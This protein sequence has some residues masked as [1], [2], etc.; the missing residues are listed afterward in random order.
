VALVALSFGVAGCTAADGSDSKFNLLQDDVTPGAC[1]VL[2]FDEGGTI[3]A[4]EVVNEAYADIG[5]AISSNRAAVAF[6]SNN[7][8]GEDFDLA[9]DG[10][11]NLLIVQEDFSTAEVEAGLVSEP[12]DNGS[13]GRLDFDF[14]SEVCVNGLTVLDVDDDEDPVQVR[15]YGPDGTEIGS[16]GV[17]PTG[18]N[19]RQ[20]IVT[21]ICGVTRMEVE[22][23]SSGA[24]DNVEVCSS[25][26]NPP[27]GGGGGDDP[28]TPEGDP[29]D[30]GGDGD[31]PCFDIENVVCEDGGSEPGNEDDY[32]VQ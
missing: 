27:G 21:S 11:G 1:K 14:A 26:D 31:G 10:L 25:G 12:D 2:D 3:A 19:T 23:N 4:G 30:D 9:F 24:I 20:D 22:L 16:T 18:N 8:T 5:V 29:P 7:P 13:G 15:F 28:G 17:F 32:V 6:D